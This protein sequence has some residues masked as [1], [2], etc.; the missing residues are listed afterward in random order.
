MMEFK[1]NI[2]GLQHIGLPT[3]Q[4]DQTIAFYSSLGFEVDL[5]VMLNEPNRKFRVAFL[6]FGGLVI[7]T[8]EVPGDAN[9]L[10]GAINHIA[11]NVKDVDKAFEQAKA[12][13]LEL[14]DTHIDS[15]PFYENGVR[16][17][18]ILG[19]N[20]EKLEFNQRM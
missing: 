13:G 9:H 1:D 15:I 14:L 4:I 8:Y 18:T 10:V 3:S 11:L 17:F 20:G 19:P 16:F 12:S 7:E 6:R 2:T 5:S